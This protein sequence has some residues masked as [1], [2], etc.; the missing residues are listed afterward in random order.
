MTETPAAGAPPV[1]FYTVGGVTG[2]VRLGGTLSPH[3]LLGG[4]I[5]GLTHHYPA[6]VTLPS[7]DEVVS[8]VTA[9]VY[10][11][12]K[13]ASGF[14]LKGGLG[15]SN[16]DFSSGGGSVTGLGGGFVAGLGYDIRVGR[17]ISI[18]PTGDFWFGSVGDLK[19][20]GS[21]VGTGW[22]QA[23]ASFGLGVTFH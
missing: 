7:A 13:P 2:F 6:T 14:F 19:S 16:Y 9:A 8:S 11:Y 20:S 21:L 5:D 18:T 12:P 10:Y 1:N 23:I 22:K 4:E 17:N 3:L 15:F